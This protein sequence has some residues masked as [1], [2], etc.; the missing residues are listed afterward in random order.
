MYDIT[1]IS[2]SNSIIN[3]NN[4]NKNKLQVKKCVW[5]EGIFVKRRFK[6]LLNLIVDQF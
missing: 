4:K 3:G 2:S 1:D 6:V 5:E